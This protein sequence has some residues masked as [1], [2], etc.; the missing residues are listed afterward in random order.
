ME[1]RELWQT[2]FKLTMISN[3]LNTHTHTH[4]EVLSELVGTCKELGC[5]GQVVIA[6]SPWEDAP[7]QARPRGAP[8][9]LIT[10]LPCFQAAPGPAP[11]VL[12][13]FF[14]DRVA[15]PSPL[16]SHC[17]FLGSTRTIRLCCCLSWA[18]AQCGWLCSFASRVHSRCL[19][20]TWS[21]Y[22]FIHFRARQVIEVGA[23]ELFP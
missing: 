19:I 18:K 5:S 13:T 21:R 8:P 22:S 7:R 4:R 3:L 23:R 2:T 9:L 10:S 17:P 16:T 20:A 14:P 12:G 11:A 6:F 1:N 15:L